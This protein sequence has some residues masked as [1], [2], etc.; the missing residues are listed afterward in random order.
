[1][2]ESRSANPPTVTLTLDAGASRL[3]NKFSG[4]GWRFAGN[5]YKAEKST[6]EYLS[7][8]SRGDAGVIG[9]KKQAQKTKKIGTPFGNALYDNGY[10]VAFPGAKTYYTYNP[11]SGSK[12]FVIN[13]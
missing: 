11:V 13:E 5:L 8:A 12:Y 10:S 2:S 9:S 3:S 6:G 1:M 4:S 7:W